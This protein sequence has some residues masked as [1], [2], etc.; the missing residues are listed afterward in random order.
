MISEGHRPEARRNDPRRRNR[1]R[2]SGQIEAKSLDAELRQAI[3]D[4]P[5]N[6]TRV[7]CVDDQIA[8]APAAADRHRSARPQPAAGV[9]TANTSR[10][11]RPA[12][13]W[14]PVDLQRPTPLPPIHSLFGVLVAESET[15]AA[16]TFLLVRQLLIAIERAGT[17]FPADG[18][19]LLQ[20]RETISLVSQTRSPWAVGRRPGWFPFSYFC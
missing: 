10:S 13:F 4:Q 18:Y 16:S 8:P 12:P 19:A 14:I 6:S 5:Q 7:G 17:F 1:K 9:P 20:Q 3:Y 11:R 2:R 15:E